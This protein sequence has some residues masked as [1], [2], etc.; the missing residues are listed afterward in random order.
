MF[1]SCSKTT[2][3]TK[4]NDTHWNQNSE[5]VSRSPR[6]V[7]KHGKPMLIASPLSPP[8]PSAVLIKSLAVTVSISWKTV[9]FASR[10]NVYATPGLMALCGVCHIQ[11]HA[12]R[13]MRCIAFV[14]YVA[15]VLELKSALGTWLLC[16]FSSIKM[17]SKVRVEVCRDNVQ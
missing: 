17:A 8:C 14:N 16:Q 13:R 11:V 6:R 2:H 5:I 7:A 4:N 9:N 15:K 12:V 3:W 10:L 1:D